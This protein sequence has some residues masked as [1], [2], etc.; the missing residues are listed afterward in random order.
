MTAHLQ[1]ELI[2]EHETALQIKYTTQVWEWRA[3]GL[4]TQSV[5]S[6]VLFYGSSWAVPYC[7]ASL[8]PTFWTYFPLALYLKFYASPH[9]NL[10][11]IN[12]LGMFIYKYSWSPFELFYCWVAW[13]CTLC[14]SKGVDCDSVTS[15]ISKRWGDVPWGWDRGDEGHGHQMVF[16][17][18]NAEPWAASFFWSSPCILGADCVWMVMGPGQSSWSPRG[19]CPVDSSLQEWISLPFFRQ[20]LF[21]FELKGRTNFQPTL[22]VLLPSWRN[23]HRFFYKMHVNQRSCKRL[24]LYHSFLHLPSLLLLS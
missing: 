13:V 4:K 3:G 11:Q 7:R 10:Q 9:K 22:P 14:S 18:C 23:E 1:T 17:A 8:I 19:T 6:Y 24:N 21:S 15:I 2:L 5:V 12:V 16:E 20:E